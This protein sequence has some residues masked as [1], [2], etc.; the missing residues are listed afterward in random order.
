MTELEKK[1][2]ALMVKIA[3]QLAEEE[4]GICLQAIAL[5]IARSFAYENEHMTA[6]KFRDSRDRLYIAFQ[7][8]YI[9]VTKTT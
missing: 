3:Y 5:Y 2:K 7:E 8:E 4:M 1:L 6:Q 9:K